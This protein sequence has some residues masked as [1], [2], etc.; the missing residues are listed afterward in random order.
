[1]DELVNAVWGNSRCLLW[2]PYGTQRSSPYFT[3]NTLRLRYRAQ[4]VNAVWGNSRC[5]L[6]E[7]HGTHTVLE[8]AKTADLTVTRNLRMH[9]CLPP[10]TPYVFL[11]G[12]SIKHS[13]S[14]AFLGHIQKVKREGLSLR[15]CQSGRLTW[16]RW[17]QSFKI[18]PG[19]HSLK[20]VWQVRFAA[21]LIYK[22]AYI[23]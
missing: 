17:T 21:T 19:R 1:M 20:V 8:S 6:W 14:Y 18:R 22:E 23:T 13:A 12:C 10:F 3:E 7:P 16:H 5:L 15:L 11:A 4:P 9:G 2:E